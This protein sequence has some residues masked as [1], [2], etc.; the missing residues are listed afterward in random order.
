M[1]EG[2]QWRR[3]TAERKFRVFLE[4]RG[5]EVPVGEILRRHGLTLEDLRAIEET[6]ERS[7]IAGLKVQAGHRRLPREVTAEEYA[8]I[9]Q[10]LREK[11][12]ALAELSVECT[13]LKKSERSGSPIG[14]DGAGMRLRRGR[15][16]SR[17]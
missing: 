15:R 7:A 3:L 1:A 8:W 10:E 14:E 12:R 2:Q 6:V 9:C 17:R 4:T 16:S 13:L 11:E 5:A